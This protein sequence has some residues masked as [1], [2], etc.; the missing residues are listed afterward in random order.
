ME[1]TRGRA[2]DPSRSSIHSWCRLTLIIQ[3]SKTIWPSPIAPVGA[4][5]TMGDGP[6]VGGGDAAWV[7]D[8]APVGASGDPKHATRTS[9]AAASSERDLRGGSSFIAPLPPDSSGAVGP[10]AAVQF[11]LPVS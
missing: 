9:G 4:G 5:V 2:P 1:W 7:W 8:A 6:I 10:V 11:S 3:S